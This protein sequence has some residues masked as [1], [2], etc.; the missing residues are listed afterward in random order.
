VGL[1]ITTALVIYPSFTRVGEGEWV[2]F[3]HH[4]TWAISLAVGPAWL[5][6]AGGLL[7]WVFA[8]GHVT[9]TW[10]LC[11]SCALAAVMVTVVSAVGRHN[12]LAHTFHRDV[13]RGLLV[14]HWVR[15]ALW[16]V[17]AGVAT[18]ALMHH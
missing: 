1:A 14:A 3:H 5:A 6:Q 16:C 9:W 2:R 13:H 4:H 12:A 11:G 7:W 8:Q 15:T 10:V 17:G 18:A